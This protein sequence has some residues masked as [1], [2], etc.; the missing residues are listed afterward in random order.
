MSLTQEKESDLGDGE[1]AVSSDGVEL[2]QG[3]TVEKVLLLPAS[4]PESIIAGP[5]R[6]AETKVEQLS[7]L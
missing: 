4:P 3:L 7:S 1:G 2:G 5:R 6:C